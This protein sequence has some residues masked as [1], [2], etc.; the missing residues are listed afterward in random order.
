MKLRDVEKY[1]AETSFSEF[2]QNRA[3]SVGSTDRNAFASS[4]KCDCHC[5]KFHSIMMRR[6]EG[7]GMDERP[8]LIGSEAL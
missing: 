6:F 7:T 1:Y 8:L 4:V 2:R 3:V 5:T